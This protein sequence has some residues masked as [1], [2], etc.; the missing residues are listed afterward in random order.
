MGAVA[1]ELFE[2][3]RTQNTAAWPQ[4]MAKA[5]NLPLASFARRLRRDQHAV[6]AALELPWRNGVVEG[7]IHRLK[8]LKLLVLRILTNLTTNPVFVHRHA[9]ESGNGPAMQEHMQFLA[10]A[11][12]IKMSDT[13]L[14]RADL[15]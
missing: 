13:V 14:I 11:P 15:L 7:Q 5:E 2:M 9:D 3:I 1:R 6:L 8:L 12:G 10:F 4:W